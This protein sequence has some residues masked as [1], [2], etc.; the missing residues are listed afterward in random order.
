[1]IKGY[2]GALFSCFDLRA[3]HERGRTVQ[4][5]D[6]FECSSHALLNPKGYFRMPFSLFEGGT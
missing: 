2:L 4:Q 3:G 5:N 6:L 1:M